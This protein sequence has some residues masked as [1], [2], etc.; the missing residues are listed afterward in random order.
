MTDNQRKC[1]DWICKTLGLTY[2][3][4]NDF[5][6]ASAFISKYKEKAESVYSEREFLR[7][8][9]LQYLYMSACRIG[10]RDEEE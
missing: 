4:T 1:I 8:Q 2:W 10:D 3:G 7:Y 9:G 5:K 6:S